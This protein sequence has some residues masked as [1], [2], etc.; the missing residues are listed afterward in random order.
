MIELYSLATPNGQKISIAL[1]EMQLKYT[2]HTVNFFKGE[3]F[4]ESFLKISPNNKIPAIVD[5]EGPKNTSV[6]IFESGAILL[7]LAE[8]TNKFIPPPNTPERV[9][10]I[11]WLFWQT[12]SLGPN[13]GQMGFYYK[14]AKQHCAYSKNRFLKEAQRLFKVLENQLKDGKPYICG[15]DYTITDMAVYPWIICVDKF[16]QMKE[17]V[18][19]YPNIESYVKR[20]SER[21]AVKKGMNVCPI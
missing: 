2:P 15:N 18:G 11:K 16:Y 5:T 8:K 21:E 1:E 3:Q 12:S 6:P 14:Y 20:I 19:N 4:E 10:C 9:N 7:Y 13:L 17:K